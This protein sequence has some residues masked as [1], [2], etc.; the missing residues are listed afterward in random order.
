[1]F[2]WLRRYRGAHRVPEGPGLHRADPL[3]RFPGLIEDPAAEREDQ[4]QWHFAEP[5]PDNFP[6]PS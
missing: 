6:E 5:D 1:V 3:T 4:D 2:R